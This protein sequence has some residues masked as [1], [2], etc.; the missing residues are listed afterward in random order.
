LPRCRRSFGQEVGLIWGLDFGFIFC[1][2]IVLGF[3]SRIRN[4]RDWLG[5]MKAERDEQRGE[6]S[7][8]RPGEGR[9]KKNR[10]K[11]LERAGRLYRTI[12]K[13]GEPLEMVDLS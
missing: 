4:E 7:R 2:S 13:E 11:T 10:R 3:W 9:R 5:A 6:R 8:W 1:W 12:F